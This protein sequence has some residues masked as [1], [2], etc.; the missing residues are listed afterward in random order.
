MTMTDIGH[1]QQRQV[2]RKDLMWWTVGKE[3]APE[4]DGSIVSFKP[5]VPRLLCGGQSPVLSAV[6]LG[7]GQARYFVA[8]YRR[9]SFNWPELKIK[10]FLFC[11]RRIAH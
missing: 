8:G 6:G 3:D 10:G 9:Y 11:Y 1:L 5:R 2:G 4:W 7:L